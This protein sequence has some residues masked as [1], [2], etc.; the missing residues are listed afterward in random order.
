MT[1]GGFAD[2]DE[3][4]VLHMTYFSAIRRLRLVYF[5]PVSCKGD[6]LDTAARDA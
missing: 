2:G 1:A 3:G 4:C 6:S 5:Q